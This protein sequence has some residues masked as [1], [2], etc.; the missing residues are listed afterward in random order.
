MTNLFT[1]IVR[2]GQISIH[3]MRM[4]RQVV[5][6][7]CLWSFVLWTVL[8]A[9]Q[10]HKHLD[11]SHFR[12]YGD[13]AV[14]KAMDAFKKG[15][16]RIK[17]TIYNQKQEQT[18]KSVLQS[19]Y[20]LKK[21]YFVNYITKYS[22]YFALR[23]SLLWL[24][25]FLCLFVY[26]GF[27]RSGQEFRRGA[28]IRSFHDVK[29]L[30]SL[31]NW[32]KGYKAYNIAGMPYPYLSETQHTLV[33][34]TTGTG[35]TVLISDIV[36]QIR[37][38]KEKA[39]IYDLKRDYV[40]WFYDEKKDFILNPFDARSVKW[41][42]LNDITHPTHLKTISQAFIPEKSFSTSD[43]IWDEAARIAFASIVEKLM[44]ESP[45]I[46]NKDLIN[47]ILKQDMN[48]ISKLVKETLA[49]AIIDPTSPKTAASV[50]FVLAANFNC[51]KLIDGS[52]SSFSI[53]RWIQ[54]PNQDS[55]L[56]ITSKE[57]FRAELSPL[58]TVWFE[59]AIQG[60]LDM[61]QTHTNKTWFV[62][63]ELP[64]LNRIPSLAKALST[65]RS[66][67]GSFILGAQNIAQMRE[68]YGHHMAQDIS[69]E[70]NTR[71]FFK[72]NDPDTARWIAQNIGEAEIKEFQEGISYGAHLMRDGINLNTT[73]RIKALLLP[74]EILNLERLHLV[75]KMADFP[76]V[77]TNLKYKERKECSERFMM[78]EE[79]TKIV[80][81]VPEESK[82][83]QEIEIVQKTSNFFNT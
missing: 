69:S 7:I 28:K 20:F 57:S 25:F 47:A 31:E 6:I 5:N 66:Y 51:L 26:K 19:T 55:I 36:E 21:T 10:M 71:A 61:Q 70:C 56:F 2:G 42:L 79:T 38:R 16:K 4:F 81:S 23:W 63:D 41:R 8:F 59:I 37:K 1:N 15:D 80:H 34:G 18:V 64:T 40:K 17:V 50:M 58:Q 43:R 29:R 72:T 62:I 52:S 74:S 32:S 24:I 46:T 78:G 53:K 3:A 77:R 65:S 67:S 54:D 73:E 68:T 27:K 11:K 75:L 35:K 12:A 82:K 39:I 30:I 45:N 14:A 76:A 60:L 83:K 49:Q 48:Q 9:Y 22:A 13:Y 33:V 44:I